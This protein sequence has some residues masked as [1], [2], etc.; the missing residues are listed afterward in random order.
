MCILCGI[1]Q[2]K[3]F[4]DYALCQNSEEFDEDL[5]SDVLLPHIL[6]LP[7]LRSLRQN[8]T[9]PNQTKKPTNKH[10][11]PRQTKAPNQTHK[12]TQKICYVYIM[13]NKLS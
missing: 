12:K 7:E 10:P 8:E 1:V 3:T 2:F 9:K 6:K 4:R 11:T 13:E 5:V